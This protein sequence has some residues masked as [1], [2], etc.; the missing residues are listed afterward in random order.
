MSR[1]KQNN[2][3]TQN[4][5]T[6]S[7]LKQI[8]EMANTINEMDEPNAHYYGR[9]MKEHE[10]FADCFTIARHL[11]NAGYRKQSEGEGEW[12]GRR[13]NFDDDFPILEKSHYLKCNK[14][15]H[16]HALYTYNPF[17]DRV[18]L[19]KVFDEDITIPN[20]CPNCGAKMKGG[21]E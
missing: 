21:A 15:G 10:A 17:T 2:T 7:E 4:Q 19:V 9:N 20:F 8:E 5:F 11:Y 6:N 18:R 12:V 1:E 3:P 14:C 16:L 13:Y